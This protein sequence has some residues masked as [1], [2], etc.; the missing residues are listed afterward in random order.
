M[1][2]VFLEDLLP[3]KPDLTYDKQYQYIKKLMDQERIRPVFASGTNGK[4]PAL[5]REDWVLE[6]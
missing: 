4:K 6:E 5:Y 1:K 2:R 3:S